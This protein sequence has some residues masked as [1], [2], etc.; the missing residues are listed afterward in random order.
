MKLRPPGSRRRE[1]DSLVV[2]CGPGGN[3]PHLWVPLRLYSI[4]SVCGLHWQS[5]GPT[6]Q[7]QGTAS[8]PLP[9][10]AREDPESP[11]LLWSYISVPFQDPHLSCFLF[12]L[13]H[14][15]KTFSSK[16]MFNTDKE[17]I[18]IPKPR[19]CMHCD[20]FVFLSI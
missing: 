4:S 17:S 3:G 20:F 13:R 8:L 11:C 9:G 15:R 7:R 18:L 14:L 2:G 12:Y 6:E 16:K 19:N 10:P 1:T 5:S